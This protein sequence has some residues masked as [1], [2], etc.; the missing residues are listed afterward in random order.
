MRLFA[1]NFIIY[2]LS[3]DSAAEIRSS[4]QR[5]T[6]SPLQSLPHAHRFEFT[7]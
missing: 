6:F 3:D 2:L 1:A 5:K 7:F 4:L